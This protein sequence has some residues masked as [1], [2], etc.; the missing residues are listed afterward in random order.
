MLTHYP[1]RSLHLGPSYNQPSFACW[2]LNPV[3]KAIVFVHG[4]SGSGLTTWSE[5]HRLLPQTPQAAGYDVIFY[6]HDGLFATTQASS[7]LFY[8]F[9]DR[10]FTDPLTITNPNL[11]NASARPHGFT[12]DKVILAGHSLGAVLCRW[13][14]LFAHGHNRTWMDKTAMVLYAPAHMGAKVPQLITDLGA[15][16]GTLG[17]ILRL[18]GI[19]AKY[20]SPLI[21]EL[22]AGSQHLQEL[23]S[24]TRTALAKGGNDYLKAKAV[25]VA[26][27]DRVVENLQFAQDP[28]PPSSVNADHISVC[29]PDRNTFLEPLA[30]LS[31]VL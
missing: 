27:R 2:S 18:L 24:Q 11:P 21:N 10:L 29:K 14:L 3:G 15:G 8:Q 22:A 31:G 16:A 7:A 12:Y 17:N 28:W 1:E 19:G 30:L 25:I 20:A 26:E 4:Y 23:L 13:A 5:F 6:G 9:L